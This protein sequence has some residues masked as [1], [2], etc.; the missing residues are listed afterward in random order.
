MTGEDNERNEE[1]RYKVL[2]VDDSPDNIALFSELL[3]ETYHVRIALNG[4]IFIRRNLA[5]T[6][7]MTNSTS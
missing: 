2:I 1:E 5:L 6:A 7:G 4:E 3:K